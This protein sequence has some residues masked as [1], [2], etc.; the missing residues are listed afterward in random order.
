MKDFKQIYQES[1]NQIVVPEFDLTNLNDSEKK[2]EII[3]K[4]QAA[5]IMSMLILGL[6]VL[7]LAGGTAYAMTFQRLIFQT[8]KGYKIDDSSP[9]DKDDGLAIRYSDSESDIGIQ[10]E[11]PEILVEDGGQQT[12]V[13]DIDSANMYMP[14]KIVEA[15]IE[16]IE[17]SKIYIYTPENTG[18]NSYESILE[19]NNEESLVNI[20]YR[21]FIKNHWAFETDFGDNFV[22]TSNFVNMY[23]IEFT[24]IEGYYEPMDK[25]LFEASVAFDNM[26]VTVSAENISYEQLKT[27]LDSMDLNSY[28]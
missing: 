26:L 6:A 15:T 8:D 5:S 1:V 12:I 19:Y 9:E 3:R 23:N 2:K 24:I 13:Y 28:R 20:T 21:F 14:F 27:I 25:T 11:I 22:S 17:L 7:V 18:T 4:R 16:D 10:Y